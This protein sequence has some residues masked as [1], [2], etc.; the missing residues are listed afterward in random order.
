[1]HCLSRLMQGSAV[2]I[3][4]DEELSDPLRVAPAGRGH[5]TAD[6]H[7]GVESTE[8]RLFASSACTASGSGYHKLFDVERGTAVM[9]FNADGHACSTLTLD[10]LGTPSYIPL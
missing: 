4:H 2:Y 7:W 10:P 9:E 5:V 6:I 3:L 8:G 1:M